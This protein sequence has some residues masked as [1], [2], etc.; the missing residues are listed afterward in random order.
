MSATAPL[1][2]CAALFLSPLAL[3]QRQVAPN[4][5]AAALAAAQA[6]HG[7]SVLDDDVVGLAGPLKAHFD[8]GAVTFTP[9]FGAAAP[10]T[11]PFTLTSQKVLRGS[12]TVATIAQRS[13]RVQ[14]GHRV[15]YDLGGG[16]T[17]RYVTRGDGIKQSFL[18]NQRPAGTG[19]LAV[20]LAVDTLLDCPPTQHAQQLTFS[21]G[22]LGSV[23]LDTIVGIDA[24]GRRTEGFMRFDGVHLDLVLPGD[25]VDSATYPLELDPVVSGIINTGASFNDNDPDIAYDLTNQVY[26]VV[27]VL[28]ISS[29]QREIYGQRISFQGA[30]IGGLIAFTN[31]GN[32]RHP[33]VGNCN[34]TNNFFVAWQQFEN[35]SWNILGASV[36]AANGTKSANITIANAAHDEV[37]PDV[38]GDSYDSSPG[39]GLCLCVWDDTQ[40]GIRSCVVRMHNDPPTADAYQTVVAGADP[41]RNNPAITKDGR[42][43]G[44]WFIAYQ[45]DPQFLSVIGLDF[46]GNLVGVPTTAAFSANDVVDNPDID[47]DG[48]SF[49]LVF[50]RDEPGST[51]VDDIYGAHGTWDGTAIQITQFGSPIEAD[52]GQDEQTPCISLMGT[53]YVA[54]WIGPQPGGTRIELTNLELDSVARCGNEQIVSAP[55]TGL[56]VPALVSRRS[57][58]DTS[59]ESGLLSHR[60]FLVTGPSAGNALLDSRLYQTFGDSLITPIPGTGC[61]L[62]GT[63]GTSGGSFAIGNENF[64]ITLTGADPAATLAVCI[65]DVSGNPPLPFCGAGCGVIAPFLTTVVTMSG[66][67]GVRPLQLSCDPTNLGFQLDAQWAVV[68]SAPGGCAALPL[69]HPSD[70]IRMVMVN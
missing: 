21:A 19:D 68:S 63:I 6:R 23:H 53:K 22:D 62:G 60:R 47:G 38:G 27:F 40:A 37:T 5:E 70:A 45:H 15:E 31:L 24:L 46:L 9:A 59:S 20:R 49:S 30:R 10:Q 58:G 41:F 7:V 14:G 11:M 57:A 17:E 51:T 33:K 65:L 61:G 39:L 55:G 3:S 2:L 29:T 56:T 12:A 52:A 50:E 13:R 43:V 18:F 66:G 28:Q 4:D 67:N 64:A 69:F 32:C 48:E 8:Q 1:G 34:S 44:R 26:L 25:F 36:D 42:N 54:G 16:M 35:N